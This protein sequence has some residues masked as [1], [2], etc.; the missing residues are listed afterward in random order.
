MDLTAPEARV[1][2][3]LIEKQL[4]TPQQ[5]P[6]TLNSLVAAC[7]QTSNRYP[8]VDYSETTFET[9]LSSLKTRGLVRYVL[10]SHGR[11]VVRYRHAVEEAIGLGTRPMALVAVLLLRGAQTPGE[12][13]TRCERL[14]DLADLRDVTAELAALSAREE[15]L[16]RR[17]PRRPGQ[18]E[19]RYAEL[20]SSRGGAEGLEEQHDHAGVAHGSELQPPGG[21]PVSVPAG[22]AASAGTDID[23]VPEAKESFEERG[24]EVLLTRIASLEADV[25][26]LRRD[27]D[28]LRALWLE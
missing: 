27:M 16:V 28:E 15:P 3:A 10:P 23:A 22:D 7:N 2:G 8:V 12:L 18:K 17:L 9:A 4:A 11:S 26:V 13:R 5:Y 25:A 14:T 19:E 1:L 6:L 21:R 24:E 20:L